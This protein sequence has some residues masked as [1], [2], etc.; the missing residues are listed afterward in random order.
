MSDLHVPGTIQYTA[1]DT[2]LEGAGFNTYTQFGED[3]LIGAVFDKI[4]VANFWCFEVGAADGFFYSN[5]L[6]LREHGWSSVLMESGDDQ[7]RSLES[8]YASDEVHCV[9]ETVTDLDCVLSRFVDCP[10][11]LD[12]GV[13]DIDGQDYWLWNDMEA[14][15][16][17]VM[18]VEFHW[19]DGESFVPPRGAGRHQAGRQS[20]IQLGLAKGYIAVAQTHVNLLF[21]QESLWLSN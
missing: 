9:H 5:T 6:R 19:A 4:G 10:V 3:G 7:Y 18:L 16:P 1:L 15:R 13:I 21:V 8:Q 2:A 17:R 12:L 20:L 11:D 14:Y